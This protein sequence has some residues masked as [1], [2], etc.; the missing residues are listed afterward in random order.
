M[1]V[2]HYENFPV[3][4]FLL[5]PVLRGPVAAIYHFARSADDFADEGDAPAKWRLAQLDAYRVELDAIADETPTQHPIFLALGPVIREYQL[6]L[7]LFY[8]LLDAFSQDVSKDRY[9]DFAE[10]SDY[11]ARSANPIGRLLLHLF[12]QSS[13]E[14]LQ[15][16]DAICTAL[17]LINHWQDV[18]IDALKGDAGRIYLPQDDM[19]RF[20][21]SE[22]AI[23]QRVAS[24]NWQSLMKFQVHRARNLMLQGAPLGWI[25]PGRFGMEVRAI[26]AGGLR[27]ADKIEA[28]DFDVF[29]HR[30]SLKAW[31]W[32]MIFWATLVRPL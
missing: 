7:Q 9:A 20:G 27:V 14:Q 30:P 22:E 23:Q 31:D 17:Q 10:L 13:T 26:V 6:P 11:C 16:S 1:P 25:L 32:P 24:T 8:Q 12:G 28:R 18:G 3:A 4:S 19:A 15:Q 5:P 29:N 2:D 21:V